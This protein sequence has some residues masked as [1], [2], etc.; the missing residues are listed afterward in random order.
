MAGIG[1]G[2]LWEIMGDLDHADYKKAITKKETD[3]KAEAAMKHIREVA[4][5]RLAQL[6]LA[7]FLLL[8]LLI[9]EAQQLRKGL[10]EKDHRRLWV[11][12]QA[13]PQIFSDDLE[14]DIFITLTRL[15]RHA[16]IDDLKDR[17]RKQYQKVR[18][19][20]SKVQD[21][22]TGEDAIP[23]LFCVLD[24]A[25]VATTLRGDD[26]TSGDYLHK[27]PVLREI[28]LLWSTVLPFWQMRLVLSGTGIDLQALKGTLESS[29]L[30]E[31]PYT[32]KCDVG[33]FEDPQSQAEYIKRYVPACWTD[34]RWSEFLVRA[35]AWFHGR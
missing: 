22:V 10:R 19:V 30:K 29:A 5:H 18:Q 11:L 13:Q 21:P 27:R 25:Q 3:P 6:L 35:W 17:I 23:P 20:L 31:Q 14:D 34:P 4:E 8:N 1:S 16:S 2:D 15:L 33:A 7:R 9:Q 32:I 26:F 28:W 24:E 12:L